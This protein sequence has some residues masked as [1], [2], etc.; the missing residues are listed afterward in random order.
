M[1]AAGAKGV[2][3]EFSHWIPNRWGGLRSNWNGNYVSRAEHALSDPYRYQFMPKAWKAENPLPSMAEQQ[4]VRIPNVYK[5]AATGGAYGYGGGN[6][7]KITDGLTHAT[8]Q[9]YDAVDRL[10]QQ[11]QPHPTSTGQLGTIGTQYNA[12]DIDNVTGV[13]DPRSLATTYTKNAYGAFN[14]VYQLSWEV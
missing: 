2:G 13:T 11:S 14:Y 3:K 12:I 4:W 8:L 10:I 9:Q 6:L 7:T 5:G 1:R